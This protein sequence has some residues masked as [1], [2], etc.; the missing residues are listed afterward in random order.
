MKHTHS[1]Q[2]HK[3]EEDPLQYIKNLIAQQLFELHCC[4]QIHFF[5][6]LCIFQEIGGLLKTGGPSL[7][8][9]YVSI[10]LIDS[11]PWYSAAVGV[12]HKINLYEE[13]T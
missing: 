9:M 1:Y 5:R 12:F 6:T 11:T 4:S 13:L 10:L 2:K 7:Y 8:F 3:G